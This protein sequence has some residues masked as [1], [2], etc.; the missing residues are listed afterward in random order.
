MIVGS[1]LWAWLLT[2]IWSKKKWKKNKRENAANKIY[3][4]LKM[5]A[6]QRKLISVARFQRAG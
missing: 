2:K 6:S 4:S 3:K 1:V 5:H